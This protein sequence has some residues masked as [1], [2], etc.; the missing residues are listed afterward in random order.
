VCGRVG[1]AYVDSTS[2]GEEGAFPSAR[3]K[4]GVLESGRHPNFL[5]EKI[6]EN[7]KTC[8]DQENDASSANRVALAFTYLVTSG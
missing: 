2:Q 1:G 5:Q 7:L 4:G 8:W 6:R 3:F